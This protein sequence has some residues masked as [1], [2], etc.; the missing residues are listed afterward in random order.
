V[1]RVFSSEDRILVSHLKNILDAE[2]IRCDVRNEILSGAAGELAPIDTWPELWV[3][4]N[5]KVDFA[6]DLIQSA[7]KQFDEKM[8]DW[9]CQCGE[10]IDGAM[11][12]CWHCGASA[13]N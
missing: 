8:D 13:P 12:I 10:T 4:D 5:L 3:T 1:T 9:Q 2:G 7:L 6:K 11:A